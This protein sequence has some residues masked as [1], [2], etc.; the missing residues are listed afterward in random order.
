MK[1]I[2][3]S[4]LHKDLICYLALHHLDYQT[5]LYFIEAIILYQFM[6][7]NPF[8]EKGPDSA[9]EAKKFTRRFYRD[10]QLSKIYDALFLQEPKIVVGA[11][12]SFYFN[13]NVGWYYWS[14]EPGQKV[15][16][17]PQLFNPFSSQNPDIEMNNL[18]GH[19]NN[20]K[21][22]N[23]GGRELGFF[24]KNDKNFAYDNIIKIVDQRNY[25]IILTV[26]GQV[27]GIDKRMMKLA[28]KY[29]KQKRSM[30]VLI[31]IPESEKVIDIIASETTGYLLTAKG[32]VYSWQLDTQ[33]ELDLS[34]NHY[35]CPQEITELQNLQIVAIAC[36]AVRQLFLT[37]DGKIYIHKNSE[38]KL[39][40]FHL[41]IK[42]KI[43]AIV[44]GKWHFLALTEAGNVYSWG[45]NKEGQL[46][47]NSE[48]YIEQPTLINE[49]KEKVSFIVAGFYHSVCLTK[50]GEVYTFGD[51]QKGQL[52]LS[53]SNC[54]HTPQL[55]SALKNKVISKVAANGNYTLCLTSEGQLYSFGLGPQKRTS[56][57]LE[58]VLD[59]DTQEASNEMRN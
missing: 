57:P 38:G 16:V 10:H 15:N 43:K 32:K 21:G 4:L 58:I 29:N 56:L 36:T 13:P 26:K 41:E 52:G 24:S 11:K 35:I 55:V 28:E 39:Q 27:F 3:L 18:L 54:P 59:V 31:K 23:Q 45:F 48:G 30:L 19:Q 46:G 14:Q 9:M 12:E 22:I 17:N 44:G 2:P 8:R 49:L 50:D 33:M 25:R 42:E 20:V 37:V 40:L 47:I 1:D 34:T 51:N 53:N 6:E 7:N 5:A